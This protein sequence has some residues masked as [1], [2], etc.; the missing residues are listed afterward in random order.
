MQFPHRLEKNVRKTQ[1]KL[2]RGL[3]KKHVLFIAKRTAV[4]KNLCRAG[5]ARRPRTRTLNAVHESIIE[6]MHL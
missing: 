5:I 2:T 6:D 4:N 1:G 3:G